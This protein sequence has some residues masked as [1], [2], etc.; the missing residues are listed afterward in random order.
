MGLGVGLDREIGI[1]FAGG[2]LVQVSLDFLV[3]LSKRFQYAVF[4]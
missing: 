2:F 4:E 1:R 3:I